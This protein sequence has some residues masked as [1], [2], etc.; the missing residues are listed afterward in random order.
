MCDSCRLQKRYFAEAVANQVYDSD[1]LFMN[2]DIVEDQVN[3]YRMT[4]PITLVSA[5]TTESKKCPQF[6]L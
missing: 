4:V 5:D 6:L 2:V 3:A 1:P